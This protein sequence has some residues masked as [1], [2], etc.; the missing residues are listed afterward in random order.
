MPETT[1][2]A[3]SALEGLPHRG[4]Y[5]CSDGT[6]GIV[7]AEV[8]G[9]A[10]V[11]VAA[12]MGREAALVEAIRHSF[13]CALSHRPHAALGPEVAFLWTGPGRWLARA[14][15]RPS[16]HLME[17]LMATI[18]DQASLCDQSDGRIA[19]TLGGP[20]TRDVLAKLCAIDLHPRAFGAG[21]IAV[22]QLGHIPVLLWQVD[23]GATYEILAFRSFA[24]S[25]FDTI[26]AAAAEF[27]VDVS[28]R[29]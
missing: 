4:R 10:L 25:F 13:G 27:G 15:E 14:Q 28:R 6:P 7:L 8:T 21:D 17:R 19:V 29:D 24:Q 5:G 26:V 9:L 23:D 22:T 20:R 12:R 1:L 11:S 18:G 3:R 16:P 2:R